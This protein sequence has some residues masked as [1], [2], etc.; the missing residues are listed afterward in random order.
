MFAFNSGDKSVFRGVS[1]RFNKDH[2]PNKRTTGGHS[3]AQE[4]C[5][6]TTEADAVKADVIAMVKAARDDK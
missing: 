6:W 4:T 3:R 1:A 2:I 5:D